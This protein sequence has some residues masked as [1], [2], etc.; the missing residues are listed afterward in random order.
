MLSSHERFEIPVALGK[1]MN[2]FFLLIDLLESSALRHQ[3]YFHVTNN[4]LLIF[5]SR[6][7]S[8]FVLNHS[9]F[10]SYT[11]NIYPCENA[12]F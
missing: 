10:F 12:W 7:H 3:A 6:S 8:F 9:N 2:L 11:S 5:D 1:L 4:A